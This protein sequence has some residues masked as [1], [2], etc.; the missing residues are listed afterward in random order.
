M[1]KREI[2]IGNLQRNELAPLEETRAVKC[3][4]EVITIS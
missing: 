3:K 2:G 1:N 4:K